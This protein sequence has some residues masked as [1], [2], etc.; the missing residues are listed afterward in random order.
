MWKCKNPQCG[1]TFPLYARK[2]EER[3]PT[4]E[5]YKEVTRVLIDRAVCPFCESFEIEEVKEPCP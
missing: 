3:K 4:A 1:R 5:F 2:T